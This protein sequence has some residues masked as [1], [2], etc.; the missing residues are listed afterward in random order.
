MAHDSDT[1]KFNSETRIKDPSK[2]AVLLM[3]GTLLVPNGVKMLIWA[4]SYYEGRV[5]G[6]N[7]KIF[8]SLELQTGLVSRNLSTFERI[9]AGDTVMNSCASELTSMELECLVVI[10]RKYHVRGYDLK[11]A[12]RLVVALANHQVSGDQIIKGLKV[13]SHQNEVGWKL[14]ESFLGGWLFWFNGEH[15]DARLYRIIS[16]WLVRGGVSK[17]S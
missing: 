9:L 2:L 5:Y 11:L 15:N 12:Q 14:R 3:H 10:D 4:N 6:S 8:V 16:R 13:Y 17:V 1:L 7:G